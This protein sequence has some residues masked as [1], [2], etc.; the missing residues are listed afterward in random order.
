MGESERLRG[1]H[2]AY[3]WEVHAA[4]GEGRMDLIWRLADEHMVE[5]LQLM[6]DGVAWVRTA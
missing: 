2:E 6:R 3:V 5:T 1:L 4:V